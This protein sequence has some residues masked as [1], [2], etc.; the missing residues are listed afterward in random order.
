MTARRTIHADPSKE[1][2]IDML[3]RDITLSECILDLIDNSVHSL[4]RVTNADVM[5]ALEGKPVAGSPIDASVEVTFSPTKFTI[6]D[7]C[8]G[9]SINDAENDVFRLG[10]PNPDKRHNGLGVYGIGMKRAMFKIGEKIVVTSQTEDEEL[11]VSI[12]VPKWKKKKDGWNLEFDYA[13]AKTTSQPPGTKIEITNLNH[14][15]KQMFASPTFKTELPRKVSTAFALFLESGLRIKINGT[16]LTANFPSFAQSDDINTAKNVFKHDGVDVLVMAGVTPR[17]DR[18]ARGW[19]V[20]CNGRMVLEANQTT[21]TG[22]NDG[23]PAFHPKYN[24]FLGFVYFKSKDGTKLPWKT[25]KE[26]VEVESAVYQKALA[27]MRIIGRPVINFLNDMY[28]TDVEPDGVAERETLAGAKAV[29]ASEAARN[30]KSS[31]AF[32]ANTKKTS[33]DAL[34]NILYKRPKKS[35]DKIVRALG[36]KRMSAAKVGEHTFDVFLRRECK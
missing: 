28:P 8:G 11:R 12:D 35:I 14:N 18:K 29:S 21:E 13:R 15:A 20:F 10:N 26:G 17:A 32:K 34:V 23:F 2:F 36:K 9:I 1:F 7:T 33:D 27:E 24:H 16:S 30:K 22:W 25:T 4:I 6:K 3:T 31:A 19:Y 5:K